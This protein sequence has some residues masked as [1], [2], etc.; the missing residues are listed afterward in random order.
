MAVHLN[1]HLS[2]FVTMEIFKQRKQYE[3]LYTLNI[4]LGQSYFM[5]APSSK[6]GY[7]EANND[8]D[9]TA[10]YLEISVYL[11]IYLSTIYT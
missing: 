10:F 1:G 7:F 2:L 5:Y 6:M 11:S 9:I 4:H 8:M 3:K